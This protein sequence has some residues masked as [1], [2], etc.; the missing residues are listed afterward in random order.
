MY[1][2]FCYACGKTYWTDSTE[3]ELCCPD[4]K[5]TIKRFV[6]YHTLETKEPEYKD[7]D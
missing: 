6:V 4:C 7:R 1:K 2:I 5:C 3:A